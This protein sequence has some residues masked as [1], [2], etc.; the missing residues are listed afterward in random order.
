M[1]DD[2]C[3]FMWCWSPFELN[4]APEDGIQQLN[5]SRL[6]VEHRIG[7]TIFPG[8]SL[9]TEIDEFVNWLIFTMN[10]LTKVRSQSTFL[11]KTLRTWRAV[12]IALPLKRLKSEVGS[13]I[14]TA[15][16]AA[17][18]AGLLHLAECLRRCLE[19]S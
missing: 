7:A 13:V 18:S 19:S 4:S 11:Q 5:S 8:L 10:C 9:I 3:N 6:I 17:I 16:F 1:A 2:S 14:R 12:Y 15:I